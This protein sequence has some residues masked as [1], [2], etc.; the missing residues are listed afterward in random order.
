MA[1]PFST[2]QGLMAEWLRSGLQI[3]VRRFDSCS[4]LHREFPRFPA[5]ST[6]RSGDWRGDPP[7][8]ARGP[9]RRRNQAD[10]QRDARVAM[11]EVENSAEH[12]SFP[13]DAVTT[14]QAERFIKVYERLIANW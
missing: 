9:D 4:G 7:D 6:C 14:P 1:R 12:G 3:R 8:R 11:N 5:S 13:P 2:V 10:G